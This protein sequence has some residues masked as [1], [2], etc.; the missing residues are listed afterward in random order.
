MVKCNNCGAEVNNSDFCFNCGEKVVNEALSNILWVLF[1]DFDFFVQDIS[2]V[3]S[4]L[5]VS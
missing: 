1:L 3:P 5:H 2:F 4:Y